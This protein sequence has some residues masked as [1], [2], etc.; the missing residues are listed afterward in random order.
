MRQNDIMPNQVV[1][2]IL[3][4]L[5]EVH[6]LPERAQTA[7]ILPLVLKEEVAEVVMGGK[8]GG[9]GVGVNDCLDWRVLH[10]FYTPPPL[11]ISSSQ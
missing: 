4:M 6:Y 1:F 9:G 7:I 3:I 2:Q 11:F 8:R 5:L 10:P